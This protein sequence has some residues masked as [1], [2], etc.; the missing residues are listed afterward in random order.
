MN[1]LISNNNLTMSSREIATITKARHSDVMKSIDYLMSDKAEK[2]ISGYAAQPFTH[3]QNKQTYYEYHISKRDSYV[4]VSQFSPKFTAALVDRWQE[5]ENSVAPRLP[6]T[7]ELALMVIKAE[8]EKEQ[9]MI[10]V[11]RLQGVCNTITA[12]FATGMTAVKFCKQLNGV[13]VNQVNKALKSLNML[14]NS[15]EGLIPTSYSRDKYFKITY[16]DY[17]NKDSD[18]EGQSA[19]TTLTMKG[20]KWLYRAYLSGKLPMKAT[21]D[22]VSSHVVFE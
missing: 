21:W 10:E 14:Q 9:A 1:A 3:E 12:Q 17:V 6:N 5:L 13:S 16:V 2:V 15:K 11:D 20:A 8:E 22:G 19:K 7:K 4:V 18:R